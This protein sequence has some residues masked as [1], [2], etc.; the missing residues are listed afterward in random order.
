MQDSLPVARQAFPCGI[1]P[2][3]LYR[4]VSF[5]PP[6]TDFRGATQAP[7]LY[8]S[9]SQK[10]IRPLK[11]EK[12]A[13]SRIV[14]SR[15]FRSHNETIFCQPVPVLVVGFIACRGKPTGKGDATR[16]LAGTLAIPQTSLF[17]G[18]G[19]GFLAGSA[20][21]SGSIPPGERGWALESDAGGC[22]SGR[23][24]FGTCW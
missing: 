8:L 10:G 3:G 13:A 7:F 20:S 17:A 4:K 1:L 15:R 23:V 16:S 9:P 6:F 5:H 19:A 24:A 14:K 22:G 2:T 18:P 21:P 11:R 12:Y